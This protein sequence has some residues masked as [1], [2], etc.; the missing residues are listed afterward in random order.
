[1]KRIISV[2]AV[3]ALL[4]GCIKDRHKGAGLKVGDCMPD[5]EVVTNDGNVITDDMLKESESVVMF[6]HTSCPDCRRTL[7]L[8]QEIFDR[9]SV[10]GVRFAIISRAES[11]MSIASFWTENGLEMPY[12]AQNDRDVYDKFASEGIPRIYVCGKDGII[13]HIFTDDPVPSYDELKFSLE[14]VIR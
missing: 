2:L 11:E 14:S 1:M 5:F 3:A 13:R 10:N 4:S 6:F 7:P 8:M 9:Y 12:S